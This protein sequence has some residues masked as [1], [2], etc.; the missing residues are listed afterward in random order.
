MIPTKA[1]MQEVNIFNNV[2]EKIT[3]SDQFRNFPIRNATVSV[4]HK[5]GV[6]CLGAVTFSVFINFR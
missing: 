6:R 4:R 3:T 1:K 5:D 2:K